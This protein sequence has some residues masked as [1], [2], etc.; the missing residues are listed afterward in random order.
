MDN[1][2]IGKLW[3]VYVPTYYNTISA[4]FQMI[5]RGNAHRAAARGAGQRGERAHRDPTVF[6]RTDARTHVHE[7]FREGPTEIPP[8]PTIHCE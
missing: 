7:D 6:R 5:L 8:K 4:C 3:Y 1:K 2:A